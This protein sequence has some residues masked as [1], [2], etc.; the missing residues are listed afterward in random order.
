MEWHEWGGRAGSEVGRR[1]KKKKKLKGKEKG[2]GEETN[3]P[4]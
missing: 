2:R 4:K 1:K 3:L